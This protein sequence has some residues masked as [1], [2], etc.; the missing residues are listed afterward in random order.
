M[1][2][3]A[4]PMIAFAQRAAISYPIV[5]VLAGLVLGFIPSLPHLMLEP[6][7]FLIAFLPPLLYWEA[8]TAPVDAMRRHEAAISG[9]VIGL[10]VITTSA[11]AYAAH[12]TIPAMPWSVAFALGAIVAPTDELASAPVLNAMKM[13]RALIAIVEGESLLNDASALIIYGAAVS[14]IVTGTFSISRVFANFVVAGIGGVAIGLLVA[15]AARET[16]ASSAGCEP[17]NDGIDHIAIR[18]VLDGRSTRHVEHVSGCLRRH[19][20][21]ALHSHGNDR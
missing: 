3:V 21:H 20:L 5:L 15:I 7:L 6:D 8:I 11:V 9:L 14:A 12:A 13:P 18:R 4:I 19:R 17:A 2:G 1:V 16:V 10:V